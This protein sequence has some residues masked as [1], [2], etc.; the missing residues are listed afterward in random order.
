MTCD[1]G[2]QHNKKSSTW[3]HGNNTYI[4][5]TTLAQ[6][7]HENVN[8]CYQVKI[9]QNVNT[10]F[11]KIYKHIGQTLQSTYGEL[12]E[13]SSRFLKTRQVS[14]WQN[15]SKMPPANSGALLPWSW[16]VTIWLGFD[17][18]MPWFWMPPSAR[19]EVICLL[20]ALRLLV[21]GVG[22]VDHNFRLVWFEQLELNYWITGRKETESESECQF[23]LKIWKKRTVSWCVM[24]KIK[25]T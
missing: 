25:P 14:V 8:A 11:F 1:E 7:G 16:H 21:P 17:V 12:S 13:S 20:M 3:Q 24:L 4:I 23:K 15:S 6:T 22:V 18:G 2:S 19:L 9:C 10:I 5:I